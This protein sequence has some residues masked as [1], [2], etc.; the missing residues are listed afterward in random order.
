MNSLNGAGKELNNFFASFPELTLF[1]RI[2]K[3]L[4]DSSDEFLQSIDRVDVDQSPWEPVIQDGAITGRVLYL[5]SYSN[6]IC[7]ISLSLFRKLHQDKKFEIFVVSNHNKINKI[8][9]GYGEAEPGDLIALFNSVGFLEIAMIQAPV[10]ELLSL[11]PGSTI[12][13]KFYD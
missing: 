13:I 8:S 4:N 12:K 1:P 6:A 9:Q 2:I 7:N 3:L 5:D 11:E 10:G